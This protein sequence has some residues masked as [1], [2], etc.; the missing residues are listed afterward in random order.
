MG[1]SYRPLRPLL[2]LL[3]LSSSSSS[4]SASK[5]R[6]GAYVRAPDQSFVFIQQQNTKL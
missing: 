6:G 1:N 3:W 5:L 4:S 2:L